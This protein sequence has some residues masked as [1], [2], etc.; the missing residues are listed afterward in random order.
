MSVSEQY[1]ERL[2]LPTFDGYAIEPGDG[3][4]RTEMESGSARQRLRFTAMPSG[5][6]VRWNFTAWE[7]ALFE[8]W[9]K[10]RAK[11][12][13]VWFGIPLLGGIGMVEHEARFKGGTGKPYRVTAR[14][15]NRFIVVSQLEV[16]ERFVLSE[17]VMELALLED[18][19][20]LISAT[21]SANKLM[22]SISGA[23]GWN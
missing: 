22:Q 14:R 16:R 10:Y 2:P 9:H 5:I 8:A 12:G 13:S 7:F 3:V 18:M 1:P 11:Q 23:G 15:G 20:G 19:N 21:Q 17:E 4:S 6:P